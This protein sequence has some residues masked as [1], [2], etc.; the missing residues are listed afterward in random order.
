MT[1][2][3][4][5]LWMLD[6]QQSSL[7]YHGTSSGPLRSILALQVVGAQHTMNTF[8]VFVGLTSGE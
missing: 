7:F 1:R 6:L 2:I 3:E 8:H 5:Q 4:R